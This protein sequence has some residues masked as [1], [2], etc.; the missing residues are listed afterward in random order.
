MPTIF[1]VQGPYAV[2]CYKG[3]AGR[4]ITDDNTQEFWKRFPS[5]ANMRG[6][7]VF[8]IRGGKGFTPAHVGKATKSFKQEVFAP[9]KLSRYQQFLA[10]YLR[11]TPVLFFVVA[12]M[13]RGA[14]NS[15]HIGQLEDFLIQAGVAAN[16]HLLNIKGTK[17]EQWGIAGV[18]R[19]GKGKT[20]KGA[21]QFRQIMKLAD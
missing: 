13:R 10:D 12:P 7:Y 6:C 20:S 15:L 16:P 9:H 2:P 19:G 1:A 8:G 3:K 11:G 18:I 17:A 4:T 5:I 14:P 21:Q